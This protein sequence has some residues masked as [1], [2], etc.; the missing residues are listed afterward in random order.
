[1]KNFRTH[2][3]ATLAALFSAALLAQA[4][5]KQFVRFGA[6]ADF[7]ATGVDADAAGRAQV[8][9]RHQGSSEQSRLRVRVHDLDPS[10]TFTL[11][12][13]FGNDTTAVAISTFTTDASGKATILYTAR[14]SAKTPKHVRPNKH[15]FPETL[16][17]ISQ[18][19]SLSI[20]NAN[21][22][23]VL[24]ADLQAAEDFSYEVATAFTATGTDPDAIGIMA[25]AVQSGTIQFRLFAM[26]QSSQYTLTINDQAVAN[27][28]A[29]PMGSIAVGKYPPAAPAPMEF[30][31]VGLK[32][33]ANV[34]ILES[35]VR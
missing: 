10:T 35:Q 21:D 6:D 1:M 13:T 22:Q 33:A 28:F 8:F 24:S 30:R 27:Y 16:S 15:A 31:K 34:V 14:E 26:G 4:N 19:R 3:L 25:A 23:V 9:L 29:D 20:A 32:N 11:K 17:D 7:V 18:L 12:A 2:T 5:P